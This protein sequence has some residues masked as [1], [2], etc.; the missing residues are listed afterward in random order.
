MKKL[1][2]GLML[3]LLT[4]PLIYVV[5]EEGN[6]KF[7]TCQITLDDIQTIKSDLDDLNISLR[8]TESEILNRK[9]DDKKRVLSD[10]N[11]SNS[12]SIKV[13]E[14]IQDDFRN[15]AKGCSI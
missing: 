14:R 3:G 12:E 1:I 2:I 15:K 11:L 4:L 9:G 7:E 13:V 8:T 10:L 6:K 5:G